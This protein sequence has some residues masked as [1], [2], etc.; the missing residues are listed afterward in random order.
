MTLTRAGIVDAA[1]AR[2]IQLAATTLITP[3]P[4]DFYLSRIAVDS[5]CRQR[6]L[7]GQL[8]QHVVAEAARAAAKRCV[9]EVS[10]EAATAIALYRRHGFTEF[11]RRR[12][13]D[14]QTGAGLEYLHMERRIGAA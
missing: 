11:D 14:P 4:D 2:R 8:L 7:G 1:A 3:A 5:T 12:V 10:P 13:E 9:L 6:G